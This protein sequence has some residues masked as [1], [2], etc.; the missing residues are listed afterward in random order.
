MKYTEAVDAIR[1]LIADRKLA[2]G[3]GLPSARLLAKQIG[4][5]SKT[6]DRAC[7]DLISKGLLSRIGYKLLV[8]AENP[9]RSSIE[10]EVCVVSCFPEG[11]SGVP[12]ILT[13]R[14]VRHRVVE[15]SFLSYSTPAPHLRK[16]LAGKPAGVILHMREWIETLRPL[17]EKAKVPVVV[18]ADATPTDLSFSTVGV[19]LFRSTEIAL[20]HLF[21]LGHR[22]IAYFSGNKSFPYSRELAACFRKVCLLL[23]ISSAAIWQEEFFIDSVLCK[24]LLEQ[25]RRNPKVTA[26]FAGNACS[27]IAAKAFKVPGEISVVSLLNGALESRTPLTTVALRNSDDCI[28]MWACTE[29]ISRIQA[30]ESGRPMPPARHALF[31][32]ELIVREST[33]PRAERRT[34]KPGEHRTSKSK[35]LK[36]VEHPTSNIQHPMDAS[37]ADSKLGVGSSILDVGSSKLQVSPWDSWSKRYAYL[38]KNR[39]YTWRQLD[40]SKLAN[41]SMT[42]KHGWLGGGPLLHFSPGLRSIH[43]VPFQVIEENRNSGRAVVTFR[44]PHTHSSEGNELPVRVELPVGGHVKALYFLHGCGWALPVAF[45]EYIVHFASRKTGESLP[46]GAASHPVSS[47]PVFLLN[48]GK[49]A[50]IPLIPIGPPSQRAFQ[51]L[52]LKPNLQD[53]WPAR[54]QCDFPHAKYVT[55]FNPAD[56]QEY[57]R[58][59]YTLEWINPR[60]KDEI[61]HVEVRVDPK[62]GPTLA[63]IAVT[64]L[65]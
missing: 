6:M 59:L 34:L 1:K 14:G 58:Y 49:V 32:P 52:K 19:D 56:P 9:A 8:C 37:V 13:E 30:V 36:N 35:L 38:K 55:I 24:T 50:R 17:L 10:G 33:A 60:P 64:A 11:N 65:L 45:A 44:S 51:R 12:R 40:L 54:E 26:I 53:W 16:V 20:R 39:T 61:S 3:S 57:E 15:A 28:A 46:A 2:P 5:H 48:S 21:D 31:V 22:R 18:C 62:A 23:G 43:G 47:S 27:T 41:H 4:C 42:R 25:R 63:L 29:V 7:Q